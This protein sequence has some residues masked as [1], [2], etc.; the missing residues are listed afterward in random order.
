MKKIHT[1]HTHMHTQTHTRTPAVGA[2]GCTQFSHERAGRTPFERKPEINL[3]AR[4]LFMR[5]YCAPKAEQR[6]AA[7]TTRSMPK[8]SE[9]NY[10]RGS[11]EKD[12]AGPRGRRKSDAIFYFERIF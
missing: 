3:G 5:F 8:I 1:I 9:H 12:V 10:R 4:L 11:G 7:E 6:A 2:A